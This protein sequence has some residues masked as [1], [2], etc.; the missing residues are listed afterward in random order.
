MMNAEKLTTEIKE[1]KSEINKELVNIT[2][3]IENVKEDNKKTDAKNSIRFEKLEKRMEVIEKDKKNKPENPAVWKDGRS[4]E[5]VTRKTP[6]ETK[7]E[8]QIKKVER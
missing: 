3:K 7:L 2:K 8:E 1:S 4:I 5:K 6:E